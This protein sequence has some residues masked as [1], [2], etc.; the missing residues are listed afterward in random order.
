MEHYDPAVANTHIFYG[1]KFKD[2]GDNCVHLELERSIDD[3]NWSEPDTGVPAGQVDLDQYRHGEE[4][5]DALPLAIDERDIEDSSGRLGDDEEKEVAAPRRPKRRRT[6][7]KL[8]QPGG[9]PRQTSY[10]VGNGWRE[11]DQ[12]LE[13]ALHAS[14]QVG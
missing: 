11:E 1:G 7:P 10:V 9:D 4:Q 8:F 5:E 6:A 3:D 13:L 14:L 12:A 2:D